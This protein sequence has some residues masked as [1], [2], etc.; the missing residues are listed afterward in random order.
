[1]VAGVQPVHG[2]TLTDDASVKLPYAVPL[3]AGALVTLW[4]R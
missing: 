4:M 3:A 1:M 2:L